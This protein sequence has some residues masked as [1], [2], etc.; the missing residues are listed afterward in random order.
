MTAAA[1]KAFLITAF[2]LVSMGKSSRT[3]YPEV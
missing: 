2:S 3:P 1:A